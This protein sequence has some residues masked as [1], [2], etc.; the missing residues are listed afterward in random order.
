MAVLY[1]FEKIMDDILFFYIITLIYNAIGL[2]I[3][4][5]PDSIRVKCDCSATSMIDAHFK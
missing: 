3:H 5:F 4:K 1:Q 2:T